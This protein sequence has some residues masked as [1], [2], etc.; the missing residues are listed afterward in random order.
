MFSKPDKSVNYSGVFVAKTVWRIMQKK[1]KER[2]Y[3]LLG[4][5]E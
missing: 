3:I 5:L 2:Q 1:V 4:R